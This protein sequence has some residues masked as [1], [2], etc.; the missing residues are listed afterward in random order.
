MVLW[1]GR[2]PVQNPT[3]STISGTCVSPY[4]VHEPVSAELRRLRETPRAPLTASEGSM[5]STAMSSCARST[6]TNDVSGGSVHIAHRGVACDVRQNRWYK[7]PV[8]AASVVSSF[9]S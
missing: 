6:S 5:Q 2:G 8:S 3:R 7:P 1:T 4:C 9:V